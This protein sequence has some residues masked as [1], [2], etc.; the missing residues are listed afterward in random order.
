MKSEYAQQ[1][2]SSLSKRSFEDMVLQTNLLFV[3][4]SVLWF[5]HGFMWTAVCVF[6]TACASWMYH[7]HKESHEGY[8]LLDRV[9]AVLCFFVT[10]YSGY[11]TLS[12]SGLVILL[13]VT[14]LGFEFKRLAHET[15]SYEGWHTAWH[16][17]VFF[18]Q[19]VLVLSIESSIV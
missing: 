2:E 4:N 7:L 9:C 1:K 5:V 13:V 16:M 11:P 12:M 14:L 17:S 15:G 18:G 3:L 6:V 8:R 19:T 10:L